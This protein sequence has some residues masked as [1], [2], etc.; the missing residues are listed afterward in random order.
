MRASDGCKHVNL[1][2]HLHITHL[3]DIGRYTADVRVHCKDC[4]LPFRF[5]G[6]PAGLD[7]DGATVSVD[8][9]EVRFAMAP[10]GEVVPEL[11]GGTPSG[12]SVRRVR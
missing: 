6:L 1:H 11:E 3:E 8:G 4:G 5:I 10:K 12:F 7:L 2:G 9:T